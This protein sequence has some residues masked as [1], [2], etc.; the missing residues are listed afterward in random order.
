[1]GCGSR[2]LGLR[3]VRV[4][5]FCSYLA[6][7]LSQVISLR[8]IKKKKKRSFQQGLPFIFSLPLQWGNQE[9]VWK[10]QKPQ[11]HLLGLNWPTS[12]ASVS[13]T[14]G[15]CATILSLGS[16]RAS[17]LSLAAPLSLASQKCLFPAGGHKR[18]RGW[19][20][21]GSRQSE[22]LQ[23]N[24]ALTTSSLHYPRRHRQSGW[25]FVS[26]VQRSLVNSPPWKWKF[27]R[28]WHN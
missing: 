14:Q 28:H 21:S 24:M 16:G 23:P 25:L 22:L 3:S 27:H 18:R 11:L 20:G 17:G 2:F 4:C 15:V 10:H 5:F 12:P 7:S 9:P 1:M 13:P 8:V 6:V 19:E 26:T